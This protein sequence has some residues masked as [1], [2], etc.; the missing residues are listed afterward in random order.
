MRFSSIA[1]PSFLAKN[2]GCRSG[3]QTLIQKELCRRNSGNQCPIV[4]AYELRSHQMSSP[5]RLTRRIGWSRCKGCIVQIHN[6]E[7]DWLLNAECLLADQWPDQD[8]KV[9]THNSLT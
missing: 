9:V 8:T 5:L 3:T 7:K 1:V 4:E 6:Q 2:S